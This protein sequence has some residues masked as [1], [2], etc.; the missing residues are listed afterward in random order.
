[1]DYGSRIAV[2]LASIALWALYFFGAG[3]NRNERLTDEPPS[4]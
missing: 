1:M 2:L 4:N 3:R